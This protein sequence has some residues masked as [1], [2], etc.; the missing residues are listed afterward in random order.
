MKQEALKE[1]QE[2]VAILSYTR[3]DLTH[4]GEDIENAI[5][6]L[7]T[8]LF[9]ETP[10]PSLKMD[11]YDI[12]DDN[13]G[14]RPIMGCVHH[15]DGYKVASDSCVLVA[16]KS[17]YDESLEGKSIDAK[18]NESDYKYPKWKMVFPDKLEE[19]DGY[20]ID[21]AK[22]TNWRREVAAEKKLR[23]KY[24]A[25]RAYIKVGDAF[26]GFDKFVKMAKFMKAVGCNILHVKDYRH[27]A[28]CF[29]Q[30]GSKGLIM[31]C[32]ATSVDYRDCYLSAL[33]NQHSDKVIF[34]EAA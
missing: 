1:L 31:P 12:A 5:K 29:S 9:M 3:D 14:I 20:S 15:E 30:D 18:G 22:L 16:V 4:A 7:R 23:G 32:V 10:T 19:A 33:F 34:F 2:A 27:A 8:A 21:F 25:R 28:G 17:D 6:H 13:N 26:F 24:G 11:L